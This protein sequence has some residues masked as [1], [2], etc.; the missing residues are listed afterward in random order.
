MGNFTEIEFIFVASTID[1]VGQGRLATKL[2]IVISVIRGTRKM[3]ILLF[4]T[5]VG[6]TNSMKSKLALS[7]SPLT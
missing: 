3:I 2:T 6:W 4:H 7:R 5:F 1:L